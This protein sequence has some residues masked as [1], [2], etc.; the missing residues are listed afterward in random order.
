M[1]IQ[2]TACMLVAAVVVSFFAL[3]LLAGYRVFAKL[4]SDRS[5]VEQVRLRRASEEETRDSRPLK[6]MVSRGDED[7][8]VEHLKSRK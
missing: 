3:L 7:E 6:E 2:F 4:F 8:S 5:A 1:C